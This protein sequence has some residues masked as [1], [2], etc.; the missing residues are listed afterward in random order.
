[1]EMSGVFAIFFEVIIFPC[2]V[3]SNCLKIDGTIF[4][5]VWV[6]TYFGVDIMN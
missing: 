2:F 5:A 1:M 6:L 3:I 4:N